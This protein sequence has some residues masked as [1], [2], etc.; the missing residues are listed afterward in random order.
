MA[1]IS[2]IPTFS[3][4]RQQFRTITWLRWRIFVNGLR[5]KG[6]T[7][8]LI[9]RIL[10]Y[11]FLAVIIFGPAVGAGALSYYFV[12]R[13]MYAYLAIP[14]WIIFLL[15]QFIG[16]STSAVGPSFDL[17]ILTR[18]PIRYRDYLLMRLSFGLMDA[19]TLSGSACLAA[20]CIGI[21]IA[22]P[23]LFLWT[24]LALFTYAI[25][26]IFFFRMVYSWT[27]RW[28]AQRRT[29]E[30][31]GG[32]LLILSLGGQ[33]VGQ[34]AQKFANSDRVPLSPFTAHTIQFILAFNW[35]LPPGLTASTIEHMHA[36]SPLL[37]IASFA[38]LLTLT[39]GFLLILHLRLHAQFL[40]ENLSEAPAASSVK[41]K[42]AARRSRL[43]AA[44]SA[45]R[46]SAGILSPTVAACLKKELIY[47][48][49]SGPKLYAL[50]MPVFMVFL[51]SIRATGAGGGGHNHFKTYLFCYGC[52]YT[53][54][55]LIQLL[56]NSLGSDSTG[57]QFYFLAP[58]HFRDVML[59]KNLMTGGIFAIEIVLVYIT[60]VMISA[61]SPPALTAATVTWSIFAF[62]IN[63]S[64]GNMRSISS[65]KGI[66]AG[67]MRRQ[68]VSG[69]SAFISF[70]VILAIIIFGVAVGWICIYL[71]ATYWTAAAVFLVLAIASFGLYLLTT[72]KLD[73]IAADH[74]EDLTREL[75][76][77]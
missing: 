31:L 54:L 20:M 27:E 56:Y 55:I 47:L 1:G 59:A 12:S 36:G 52:A 33:F 9:I 23:S 4:S 28:F 19:T 26:N 66:E 46:A 22:A 17:S 49:R 67:K 71:H 40:G 61:P 63:M 35:F 57:V 18:F 5:R 77:A 53:Q 15:W 3:L 73:G 24:A 29:R 65:P 75:S 69:L 76:K 32:L 13:G 74:I 2:P 10:S 21:T 45:P 38:G 72:K 48:K 44:E 42:A 25:C 64:I 11:P 70:V 41:D 50:I 58:F 68:N 14:L 30:L 16:V 7:G 37:A 34:F 51:F 39:A 62:F 8:E 60:S 43:L 6:A